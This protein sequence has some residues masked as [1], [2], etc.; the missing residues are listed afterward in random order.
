MYNKLFF[1]LCVTLKLYWVGDIYI[2][3]KKTIIFKISKPR[4]LF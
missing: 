2:F 1:S 3:L 4:I